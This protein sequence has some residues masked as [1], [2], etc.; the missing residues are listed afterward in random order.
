MKAVLCRSFGGPETLQV[1]EIGWPEPA[2]NEV[3][4]TVKACGVNFPDTLIIDGKYQFKP[5]F[6]FSPGGEV[7]GV[8]R[9]VGEGVAH[10]KPGD[11]VLALTGW[12]GFAEGVVVDARRVFPIP[13]GMDFQTAASMLYTYGTS[14]HALKDRAHL[15]PGETLLVLGAAGGVGLAAVT[16][17]KQ[18]GATVIA[19]ASTAEKLAL[20]REYGADETINYSEDDLRNR[21]KELTGGKGVD[22]VYD[23]VGGALTDPALRSMNWNGRYLVVGFAAGKIPD[24]PMNLPLLKGCSVV[25]VFWGAFAERQPKES[26]RNLAEIIGFWQSGKIKPHIQA[27]YPLDQAAQALMDMQARKVMGKI[28]IVP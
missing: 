10:L 22:V 26:T 20:C 17:G 16:L 8:I 18:M 23:P 28:L 5:P 25:G 24:L 12:G 1:D 6:P 4:I 21:L 14:Y 3:L 2:R 9:A 7:A 27:T 15:Q 11:A 13:P 19:A